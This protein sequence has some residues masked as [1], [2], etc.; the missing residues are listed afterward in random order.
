[1]VPVSP[2][3][4]K[5]KK[6]DANK[7]KVKKTKVK[8]TKVKKTKAK[9]CSK[10]SFKFSKKRKKDDNTIYLYPGQSIQDALDGAADGATIRLSPGDYTEE[11][12]PVYGLRVTH[13]NVRLVGATTCDGREKKA[14]TTRILHSGEQQVGVYAAPDG[15]EY[16]DTKCDS[17]L[18]GFTIEGIVVEGFPK[19]GI[20]TRFVD[21]FEFI[22]S[23][24]INNLNNGLYPTLSKNGLIK[25]CTSAGSLDAGLWVAGSRFIEVLNN[26]VSDSVTGV[27]I[28]V[29]RDVRVANNKVYEN[30]V[31]I[32]YYH[33]NMA[34][35][36]PD[37][38]PYSNVVFENNRV[39][40]NNRIND[41]PDGSFQSA[42]PSG[43][44]VLLVGVR[45]ETVRNNLI[46]DNQFVGLGMAG[47]CTVQALF[48]GIADCSDDPPIDGDPSA[49][50]NDIVDNTFHENGDIG[51]PGPPIA[52]EGSDIIY[53]QSKG[54][55]LPS[56]KA[57][58]NCFRDNVTPD[59]EPA[60]YIASDFD[61]PGNRIPLPTGGCS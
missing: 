24:S 45:G 34:G 27:E 26:D 32:G 41:A 6:K 47:F 2:S 22:D 46:K 37:F 15:C 8:K 61:P 28:T 1:M 25:G 29:S 7:A 17:E 12:N 9:K 10:K 44:G 50:F 23:Q 48:F 53:I 33:A 39:Y 11:G 55:F 56:G 13:N 43:V 42:L 38:P 51:F 59:G 35:T 40:D 54:E 4:Q 58:E 30:C 5:Q 57:N 3:R 49:N 19:N 60:T 31:G 36:S 21:G 20:Q 14:V 18:L 52:L 16:K